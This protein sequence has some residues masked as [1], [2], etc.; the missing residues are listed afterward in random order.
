MTPAHRIILAAADATGCSLAVMRSASRLSIA[1]E[2]RTA[3]LLETADPA[4]GT[5]TGTEN[6]PWQ[7]DGVIVKGGRKANPYQQLRDNKFSVLDWLQSKSMLSPLIR[8]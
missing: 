8:R 2:A 5:L 4:G 7:A 3:A 1:A 6:G